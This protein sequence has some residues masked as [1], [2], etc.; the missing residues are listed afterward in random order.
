MMG[1]RCQEPQDRV[2]VSDGTNCDN[3]TCLRLSVERRCPPVREIYSPL[4]IR[5]EQEQLV[6][7]DSMLRCNG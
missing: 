6:D 4:D 5:M 7:H 3:V 1:F 2:S